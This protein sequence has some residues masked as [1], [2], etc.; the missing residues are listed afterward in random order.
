MKMKLPGLVALILL[1]SP[2][3][4]RA[5][6]NPQPASAVPQAVM[7]EYNLADFGPV[8]TIEQ[9]QATL[10]AAISN[11]IARGGGILVIGPG[12]ALG[13]IEN[14]APSSIRGT[15]TVTIVDRR[16]GYESV[17]LPSNGTHLDGVWA[18][19]RLSRTV[20]QSIDGGFG[21]HSTATIDTSIAGGTT[22]YFQP[23]LFDIKKGKD[24]RIY[25]STIRGLFEGMNFELLAPE[26]ETSVIKSLGWDAEKKMPYFVADIAHDHPKGTIILNKHV[27]NSLTITD[28]SQSDSQSTGLSVQ[29]K[30][31]GIGD[32][33]VMHAW[34]VSQ[35][36]IMSTGGDEGG[37]C[38][39]A[40]I[41]N[42]LR[43]FRGK[44]ESI[45]WKTAE[46]VYAPGPNVSSALGTSRP[47]INMNTNKHVTQGSVY[48]VAPGHQDPWD[49]ANPAKTGKTFEGQ[50][51]PGGAII[52]SKDCGWTTDIVGRFF[53]IDEPSEYIDPK[54]GGAGYTPPPDLRVY[55]W[56]Q[57]QKLEAR[58]DGTMRIYVER[59][60]WYSRNDVVPN[61]YLSDNYTWDGHLKPLRY[62]IVPGA[63][64]ADISRAWNLTDP[65]SGGADVASSPRILKLAPSPDAGGK[66]DFEKGDSIVQAIGQDPWNVSGLRVCHYNYLPSSSV[67]DASLSVVN[68]GRVTVD[69]ALNV[70][71]HFTDLEKTIKFM[72]DQQPDFQK[73]IDINAT[74]GVGIRFGA[75]VG[76]AAIMF[77]QPNQRPQPIVWRT[78][79][80]APS[81]L[82][83]DPKTGEFQ[84][85]GGAA[86][87]SGLLLGN[88]Q[89]IS[90]STTPARNLRGIAVQVK[91]GANELEVRFECGE[92]D[93]RY[94]IIVQPNWITGAAVVKRTEKGFVVS[95]DQPAPN[96][97]TIDWILVR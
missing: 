64:V 13:S 97:A 20:R 74:A 2:L 24:Q 34:A 59:T 9:M 43:P 17:F 12:A 26:G 44:I 37:L 15:N 41:S 79:N 67:P 96:T 70:Y 38:Y 82:T 86:R 23:C 16:N 87:L 25:G 84:F 55:R 46:L 5:E 61:L 62:I 4:I 71:G 22:S 3:A 56:Y 90:G 88:N 85:K 7:G 14:N 40:D 32:S 36:N 53:A 89:G 6:D 72:K 69:S 42:D 10:N 21:T 57:I 66:F 31:Y 51:L 8:K 76:E 47:L 93:A 65:R 27:V 95:F 63:Y 73:V 19:R 54:E 81:S 60:R 28:R 35:G 77:E 75:D 48:V 58:T 18:G 39:G 30:N 91:E 33:F 50:V 92:A 94:G 11:I 78:A 68:R 49:S 80:R 1:G 45:N 83:V 29:R 52:G